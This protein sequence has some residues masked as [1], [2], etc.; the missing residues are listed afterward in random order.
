MLRYL[1]KGEAESGDLVFPN[2]RG[3]PFR[4]DNVRRVVKVIGSRMGRSD[5]TT[6]TLRHTYAT[7]CRDLEDVSLVE[8]SRE[9][10]H[11][12]TRTTNIYDHANP[13]RQRKIAEKLPLVFPLSNE[14]RLVHSVAG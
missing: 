14:F 11:T 5:I 12:S 1:H 13:M 9:L 7:L 2:G 4:K 6:H 8:V 10:G 3:V